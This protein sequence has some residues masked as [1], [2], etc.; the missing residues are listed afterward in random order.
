M[1]SGHSRKYSKVTDIQI[2]RLRR[3]ELPEPAA[4]VTIRFNEVDLFSIAMRPRLVSLENYFVAL[5]SFTWHNKLLGGGEYGFFKVA[6]Q[7]EFGLGA[8]PFVRS[9]DIYVCHVAI[10]S[11]SNHI[12]V[13][14]PTPINEPR[15][16][17]DGSFGYP[18]RLT[19]SK[20]YFDCIPSVFEFVLKCVS[21]DTNPHA[22]VHA[23]IENIFCANATVEISMRTL[24]LASSLLRS[25]FLKSLD[26]FLHR[27]YLVPASCKR[28]VVT[29]NRFERLEFFDFWILLARAYMFHYLITCL[30]P[31]PL[32]ATPSALAF[33]P[34]LVT[35]VAYPTMA[36]L[37]LLYV[38]AWLGLKD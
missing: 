7:R 20:Y 34:W 17:F 3:L 35:C 27:T 36:R 18:C 5:I 32:K 15:K 2:W 8:R 6:F 10:S 1:S 28:T 33:I 12:S 25:L 26:R 30:R 16:L 11:C 22:F 37:I 29:Y 14:T 4:A 21:N 24:V 19:S 31:S 38:F 23:K 13:E 9:C